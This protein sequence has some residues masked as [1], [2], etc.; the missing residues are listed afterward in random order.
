MIN[1]LTN[2]LIKNIEEITKHNRVYVE[3]EQK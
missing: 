2:N 3:G 1:N